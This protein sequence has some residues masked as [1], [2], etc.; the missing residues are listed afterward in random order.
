MDE[1]VLQP[2]QKKHSTPAQGSPGAKR[3]PRRSGRL[4]LFLF[5]GLACLAALAVYGLMIRSAATEKLEQQANQAASEQTVSVVK[6]ERLATG[7]SV[8]LPGQTQAYVQAPVFAQTSGYLKKWY[9]DIGAQVKAGDIL[10]EIDTPQVDQQLNQSKATLKEAQAALDLSRV[11]YRRDQDLLQRRVIAQQDF[12]TAASDLGVKQATV[13]ADEAAVLSLQALEDF[14]TVKAPFDGIVT[15]RNTDI[16]ALVNSGSGNPLFIVAQVKPLRV[17]INVPEN[18][19]QDVAVGASAE[20]RFNEFPGR[21]FTGKVVR[22]A[23]AIDPNSRTLLTEVDVPNESGE[24]FPGAY[25]QVRL[26]TGSNNRSVLVPANTLLFRSE[27][28]AV[29]VVDQNNV[30]ELKKIKIGRDLGNQL[31]VTQGVGPDDRIIINPPDSLAAGQKV[32]V[33]PTQEEKKQASATPA[34]KNS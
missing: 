12:D 14:K 3:E 6:P 19:A 18:M 21:E 30:V 15:A 29:G 1:T 23:G 16:G 31:E 4:L 28:A 9:F 33:R 11:T 22:T 17:Y 10:G 25:T 32:K 24:L 27:G 8:E 13:N 26:V 7:V 34:A 20:L 2:N 5:V